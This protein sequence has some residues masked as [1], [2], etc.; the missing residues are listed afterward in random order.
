MRQAQRNARPVP[1]VR[2]VT[3]GSVP[4]TAAEYREREVRRMERALGY[5][6][7][8]ARNERTRRE[9]ENEYEEMAA[10]GLLDL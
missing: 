1:P 2:Q 7:G 6:P 5:P 9:I 8:Y 4:I 10:R 3:A